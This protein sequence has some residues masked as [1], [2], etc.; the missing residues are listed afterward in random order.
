MAVNPQHVFEPL[1]GKIQYM[2]NS[3]SCA[4]EHFRVAL[5]NYKRP[6]TTSTT[7]FLTSGTI[8][9]LNSAFMLNLILYC[10]AYLIQA[11]L[12]SFKKSDLSLSEF[13]DIC[14]HKFPILRRLYIGN[15]ILFAFFIFVFCQQYLFK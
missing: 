6:K 15:N 9:G 4:H 5:S 3:I 2:S 7:S 14:R 8:S 12:L 11:R 13:F 10:M 1:N